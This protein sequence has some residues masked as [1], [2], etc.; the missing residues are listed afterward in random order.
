MND[1][2]AQIL[3]VACFVFAMPAFAGPV[4]DVVEG[5]GSVVKE[6][7]EAVGDTASRVAG[8]VTDLGD[9]LT[10]NTT[11]AE[12]RNTIDATEQ[13]TLKRLLANNADAKRLFE[14]S[15]GYAVFDSRK[16]SF[17]FTSGGGAGVAVERESGKR[18]YMKMLS[19]GVHVGGGVQYFQS[20]FLFENKESF[21][22]FVNKGWEASGDAAAVFGERALEGGVKFVQGKAIFQLND[23]GIM[24]GANVAGTKY[25]KS[26]SLNQHA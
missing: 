25:W 9:S 15:F 1:F 18:S 23:T 10:G 24:L 12:A 13:E 5:A 19:G 20:V 3:F 16:F 17:L 2:R 11:P 14:E 26:S 4:K 6:V 21:E 22:S 8:T 7:G